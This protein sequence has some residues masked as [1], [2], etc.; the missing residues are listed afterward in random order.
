MTLKDKTKSIKAIRAT[1][2][3]QK[4]NTTVQQI[5]HM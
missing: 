3:I 2:T 1:I 5:K 4:N